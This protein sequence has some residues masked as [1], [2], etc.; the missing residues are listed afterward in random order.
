MFIYLPLFFI[1]DINDEMK[2]ISEFRKYYNHTIHPEL[3]RQE[4]RRRQL[5]W[6]MLLSVFL[7]LAVGISVLVLHIP[8]LTLFALVPI[9]LYMGFIGYK[10]RQFVSGFK[11]QIVNL[12]L[13]FIAPGK[14]VYQQ[15]GFI[16][17]S[18]FQ[19]S[20]IFS[21]TAEEYRGE[22]LI[23]GKF[24]LVDFEM[25]ELVV[26]EVYEVRNRMEP[27]FGGIFFHANFNHPIKGTVV[28]FPKNYKPRF[29]RTIKKLTANHEGAQVTLEHESF[30]D[31]F[32][33]YAEHTDE[34]RHLLSD[35]MLDAIVEYKNKVDKDVY[36][37][38]VKD[39]IYIAVSE[40]KDIL[41]PNI[42][43]SNV[44]Y[45]LVYEF[46]YDLYMILRIVEDFELHH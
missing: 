10:M 21:T 29:S 26:R 3:L 30:N 2:E 33:I 6:L 27:V 19:A 24:G 39:D 8:A 38:F 28:I 36:V 12:I 25:C 7:V 32:V 41:E 46:Y 20:R 31:L 43:L 44:N 37:S 16:P 4:R 35:G 45:P 17:K 34:A 40:P 14:M 42:F 1:Y 15:D 22:D 5:M 18:S 11:P 13:D 9:G 23:K